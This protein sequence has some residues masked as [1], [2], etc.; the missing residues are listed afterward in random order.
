MPSSET[1]ELIHVKD[2]Q[3]LLTDLPGANPRNTIT[4]RIRTLLLD[5]G[6]IPILR[7]LYGGSGRNQTL[8]LDTTDGPITSVFSDGT[9]LYVSCRTDVAGNAIGRIVRVNLKDFVRTDALT[10]TSSLSSRET[11]AL[12]MFSDGINIYAMGNDT[13]QSR[14]YIK[15]IDIAT[16][17]VQAT[18][19]LNAGE[20][21]ATSLWSD[22]TTLYVG[23]QSGP[24]VI[25]RINIST[26]TRVDSLTLNVGSN[27]PQSLFGDESF[28][29][30]GCGLT[31]EAK[32]IAKIS[33]SSFTQV[34]TLSIDIAGGGGIVSLFADGNTLYVANN[35]SGFTG[36]IVKVDL[37]TFTTVST[38]SLG[39][40]TINIIFVDAT[41]IY[42]STTSAPATIIRVDLTTFTNVSTTTFATGENDARG[43]FTDETFLYAGLFIAEP[44]KIVRRYLLPTNSVTNRRIANMSS[45]T[46]TLTTNLAIVSTNVNT[47]ITY[48]IVPTGTTGVTLTSGVGVYVPGAYV[49]IIP[50]ASIV[51]DYYIGSI[52]ISKSTANVNFEI[53]IATGAAA[54]EVVIATIS[55]EADSTSDSKE[56]VFSP[57]IKI[58][59][60]TR[61]SARC[62]DQSGL[63]V[64]NIKIRY[65]V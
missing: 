43:L 1:I 6:N 61:I 3:G 37:T 47:S 11:V 56:Y 44:S 10:F 2:T 51:T 42:V 4:S 16:F 9:N 30:A 38:L 40:I 39:A 8:T 36:N 29:Y 58:P 64:V 23:V 53:G 65:R 63:G 57:Q 17:S 20:I 33:L 50:A 62:S 24:G 14:I 18:L 32:V 7:H 49:Q 45:Q 5:I 27:T 31:G 26:F 59:A 19:L 55:H 25:V 60:N 12:S 34:G 46:S 15:K 22:G 41:F 52:F 54:S 35:S 48:F 21:T 28:L 13:I